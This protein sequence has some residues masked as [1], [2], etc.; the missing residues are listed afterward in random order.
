MIVAQ[1]LTDQDTDDPS[2]VAPLLDQIDVRIAKVTADAAYDDPIYATIEAH[3][4]DI[5]VVI[6]PRSTTV[7]NDEQGP[8]AQRAVSD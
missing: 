6:S 8:F 2:Q 5:E 3:G 1:T 7:T 4:D